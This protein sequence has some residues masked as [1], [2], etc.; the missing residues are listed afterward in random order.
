MNWNSERDIPIRHE[1]HFGTH[2]IPCFADRPNG[3]YEAFA[4]AVKTRPGSLALVAGDVRLS[5]AE[6]EQRAGLAAAGLAALG[7][8]PG[9]RIGMLISNRLEFVTTTLA[10]LRLG[11]IGVP[12]GTRLQM[13]EIAYI[14][15]HSGSSVLVHDVDLSEKVPAADSLP[16]LKHCVAAGAQPDEAVSYARLERPG[17]TLPPVHTGDEDDVALIMYTSGTTGRPKGAML[18]RVNLVHSMMNYVFC[19]RIGP[20]D[21]TL[22]AAPA[23]H[24]TGVVANM[25]MAWQAQCALIIMSEFKARAFLELAHREGITHT[26]MVPAMYNLCLLQPDFDRFDL[27][28]WRVGGYGGAPMAEATIASLAQKLPK[29]GLYN[30]YGSTETSG[31]VTMLPSESAARHPDS[32]GCTLPCTEIIVVDEQGHQ[33][34]SGESGELWIRGPMV[35]PGYWDNPSGTCDGF[36]AGYWRSGD[37]G[38]VDDQGLFRIHDRMKDMINRGGYK[39][40]SVEVEHVLQAHPAVV[41]SAIVAKPCPVLGQRVHAFVYLKEQGAADEQELKRF[42]AERLADYKVPES[43]TLTNRPL[44][45]NANGKL[46]K[47]AMREQIP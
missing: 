1:L 44:P 41:E 21:R 46:L 26:V 12:M 20:D 17:Q 30:V 43:I 28:D 16:K 3:P 14:L 31:P 24:V 4:R 18:T 34:A 15:E 47:R 19:M 36:V 10:A 7:V 8:K 9:D 39:I 25:M 13:P 45:R 42:C 32:T 40:Y 23:S 38:S 5:Y 2:V 33:V 29:L 22:M 6:L 27:S 35:V 37:L 11:A